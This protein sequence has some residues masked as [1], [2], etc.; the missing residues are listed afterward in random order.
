MNRWTTL[1]AVVLGSVLIVAAGAALA[2]S[3]SGHMGAG[4]NSGGNS[5]QFDT[6]VS[7][8]S[9][10]QGGSAADHVGAGTPESEGQASSS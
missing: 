3:A 9:A 10:P 1:R 8:Q 7:A 4:R 2:G 6:G 5:R